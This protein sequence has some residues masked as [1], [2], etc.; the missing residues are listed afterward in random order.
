MPKGHQGLLGREA[1]SFR[2]KH[3]IPSGPWCFP[4][5]LDLS[6]L[7]VPTLGGSLEPSAWGCFCRTQLKV[8]AV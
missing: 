5:P 8:D 2:G 6:G 7:E 3:V 4:L 1:L